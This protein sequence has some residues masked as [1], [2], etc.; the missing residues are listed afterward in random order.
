MKDEKGIAPPSS[1]FA[2]TQYIQIFAGATL[3]FF[4]FGNVPTLNNYLGNLFIIG[5][6]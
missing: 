5:A 6:G 2:P 1:L 4:I 3:G